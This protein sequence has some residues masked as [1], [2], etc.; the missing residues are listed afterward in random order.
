MLKRPLAT[1]LPLLA[2]LTATGISAL[3]AGQ[4]R[5]AEITDVVDAFDEENDNPFDF[6]IEPTFRQTFERGIIAREA[7]CEDCDEPA[8][9]F[10]RELDYRRVRT[11]LD[12][13]FQI[14][15]QRDLELH[16]GLPLV[17]SDRRTLEYAQGVTA[18]NSAVDP[19]D[20]R[21]AADLD[22]NIRD[23][24]DGPDNGD[25]RTHFG[26]YRYFDVPDDGVR[27]SGL[28]D[29]TIGIAWAPFSDQRNPHNA[30]LRLGVDYLAPTG[31]PARGDNTGAG[32]GVHELQVSIAAS[33]RIREFAE[34]YFGFS[35]TQPFAASGGLFAEDSPNSESRA[36][37]GRMD[38]TAGTE[39]VLFEDAETAQHYSW[40]L[41]I[42]F[43]YSFE[44][45]DY[46]PISDALSRSD[47]NGLSAGDAGFAG[48]GAG[49]GGTDGNAYDPDPSTVT[50]DDAAC[51]WVVQQPGNEAGNSSADRAAWTYEHDGITDIEGYARLG[52]HTR[53][54]MQ[55]SRYV[56]LRIGVGLEWQTPHLLTSA[57]SGRDADGDDIVELDPDPADGDVERNPFYNLTLDPVG[58]RFRIEGALDITWDLAL[59]FQF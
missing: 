54:N 47:C 27:R 30:T 37:G 22:P 3:P 36:P 39:I 32:R 52:G 20:E 58:R 45:R 42:N 4:A 8:T 51:A 5:A 14:G 13:D 17:I 23:Y 19:S 46:S 57:D 6:H 10:R 49:S 25:N 41:G 56:E 16:I 9:V 38:F 1:S 53:F 33:R 7:G 11:I 48:N 2:A 15:L 40:D 55:F 31:K 18:R 43:G 21:I 29:M 34:P 35:Y 50:V 44:G 59:A 28:G 24:Y 12:F 26:T